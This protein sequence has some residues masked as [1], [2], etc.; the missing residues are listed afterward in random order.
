MWKKKL[1]LDN[2]GKTTG[3]ETKYLNFDDYTCCLE[4]MCVW[5]SHF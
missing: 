4:H 5:D 2:M 3:K 1:K